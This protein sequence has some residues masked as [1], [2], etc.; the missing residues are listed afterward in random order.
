M[1]AKRKNLNIWIWKILI[2]FTNTFLMTYNFKKIFTQLLMVIF[3]SVL[4][5]N[6]EPEADTLGLQLFEEGAANGKEVSF[7]MIAYNIDNGDAIRSDAGV[8]ALGTLGAFNEPQFGLQKASYITQARLS[9]YNPDFGTN[10]IMDSAVLVMKPVYETSTDSIKTTTDENYVYPVGNI[11]AKK[12]V[13]TAPVRKYGR[14]KINGAVPNYTL[15]VEEISDF[16]GGTEDSI[17]SNKEFAVSN[18][19]GTKTFAGNVTSVN[20]TKDSDNSSIFTSSNDVRVNLD[21]AY[22]QNK[23]INKKGQPELKEVANFIRYFRGIKVSVAENDGYLF[24]IIPSDMQIILYYKNDK[25]ENNV[26]T[27]VSN[28]FNITLGNGNVHAGKYEYNRAGSQ[29][30]A[31]AQGNQTIGDDKVFVQGMGGPSV[32]LKFP[33]STMDSLKLMYNT[34]KAA[35]LTARVRMYTDPVTWANAYKKPDFLTIIEQELVNGVTKSRLIREMNQ[36]FSG[37]IPGFAYLRAYD[38]AKNPAYY[39]FTLTKT[40]KDMVEGGENFENKNLNI[41]MGS[42]VI[43]QNGKIANWNYTSRPYATERVQF[44][45]TGNLP[46]NDAKRA[47]L[48][49]IYGTK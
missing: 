48:R 10:A 47:K 9:A 15:R 41:G 42:F 44:V 17:Y 2:N 21:A 6:C 43:L 35:I 8:L 28:T 23:I 5:Y 24:Q 11:A 3:G 26:T 12:V 46:L 7:G 32:G 25:V 33:K 39:D 29:Y 38:L 16:L 30:A 20:I 1:K 40:V 19:L 4:L 22:F 34:N 18:L 14:A 36:S 49:I 37:V 27:R 45:G 13:T 31:L